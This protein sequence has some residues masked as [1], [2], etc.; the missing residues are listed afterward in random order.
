[1][2]NNAPCLLPAPSIVDTPNDVATVAAGERGSAVVTASGDIYTWGCNT[3][4]SL[5]HGDEEQVSAPRRI[6]WLAH[7]AAVTHVALGTNHTVLLDDTGQA[8]SCGVDLEVWCDNCVLVNQKHTHNTGSMW[9]GRILAPRSNTA[10][11]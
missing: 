1:M 3:G 8:W 2:G 10:C 9:H 4:G 5:G 11:L 7:R 6:E